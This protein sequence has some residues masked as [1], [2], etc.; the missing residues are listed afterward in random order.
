[1]AVITGSFNS[2]VSGTISGVFQNTAGGVLS[3]VIGTPGPQGSQGEPG[4]GVP[5]GGSAGQALVKIDGTNYNTEW[6]SLPAFLTKAGNLSG[7]TDLAT[8][9]DNL[10]LGQNNNPIFARVDLLGTF[11]NGSVI[12]PNSLSI[13]SSVYGSFAISPASGIT[14]PDATVQ[15]TAYPGG[16]GNYLLRAN[17]L[18]DLTDLSVARQNL[19]LGSS[20]TPVFGGVAVL[21]GGVNA[22]QISPTAL[23]I[24]QTGHGYF[25]IQPSQGIVFPDASV[26]TTAWNDAPS[27]GSQYA[28]QDGAWSVVSA[29]GDYLPLAGGTMDADASIYLSTTAGND[30]TLSGT[31][32]LLTDGENATN[33]TYGEIQLNFEDVATPFTID[34]NGITFPDAT[35]QNTAF[36]DVYLPLSGGTMT[37]SIYFTN[38]VAPIFQIN[39]T[40]EGG[41]IPGDENYS[42][43]T[44]TGL[45]FRS[46]NYSDDGEGGVN[47]PTLTYGSNLT[48]YGLS[49]VNFNGSSRA[50]TMLYGP[51]SITF[52]NASVQTIAFPGFNNTALTGTPTAPTAALA[53]NDT[54]IATTAFVQQELAS[55]TANAR[56]LEVYVRNQTGSTIPIG[57]IVYINGATGNRPTITLAQAN[58]DANSAQTIGFTKTAIANNGFGFVIIRG[59][60]EN[61]NTNSL[62]EGVQLY[63]SPTTAGTWTT[64]KPSAPQHLVYVGIVI[65]AHPTLGVILVSVQ[66]GYELHE[67]HDVALASEANNDLLVYELS[68]DLW[69]NKSFST[70][71]LAT[72]ASPTFTGTPSPAYGDYGGHADGG[73]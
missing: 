17:N 10:N 2:L 30:V 38:A 65:R 7:L 39:D 23:S 8:A 21:G 4:Q 27:D 53:D 40:S 9:R 12:T 1:M 31:S 56:N 57:S 41:T 44:L 58:N 24:T 70:L 63:L 18:S 71:G 68:T 48:G 69:K 22:M 36:T 33:I 11:P 72:L 13:T 49:F 26:Q 67:L 19:N 55:G 25:L 62:T 3:G 20:D 45:S 73:R 14:F 50:S 54:S 35:V 5:V 34:V 16:I 60:L 29:G 52:G 66:N 59:E 15:T 37:G 43:Y 61:L 28:R 32:L 47:P 51:T 6:S 42:E 46:Q 64:T